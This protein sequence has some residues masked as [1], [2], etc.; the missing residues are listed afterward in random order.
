[1]HSPFSLRKRPNQSQITNAI[2]CI[3]LFVMSYHYAMPLCHAIMSCHYDMPSI[4]PACLPTYLPIGNEMVFLFPV[5]Y[6]DCCCCRCAACIPHTPYNLYLLT[7]LYLPL[8]LLLLL[9]C[10]LFVHRFY[11]HYL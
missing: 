7:D 2:Q 9:S 8:F 4:P 6:L 10:S 5:I 1:M 11:V 3:K